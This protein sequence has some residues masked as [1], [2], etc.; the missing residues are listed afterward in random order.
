M[1]ACACVFV[2]VYVYVCMY[3]LYMSQVIPANLTNFVEIHFP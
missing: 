2:Y 3:I 1:C